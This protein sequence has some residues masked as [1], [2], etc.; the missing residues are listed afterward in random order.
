MQKFHA[1]I[2][3]RETNL[4]T[5][6]SQVRQVLPL[7]CLA[8]KIISNETK[9]KVRTKQNMKIR[10]FVHEALKPIL[11]LWDFPNR[12]RVGLFQVYIRRFIRIN[13]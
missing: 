7:R 2:W 3:Q 5:W 12:L 11:F 6:P 4:Y 10:S 1:T 8:Y 13:R 9:E